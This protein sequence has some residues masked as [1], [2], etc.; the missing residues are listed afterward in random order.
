MLTLPEQTDRS[1]ELPATGG[2]GVTAII[3]ESGNKAVIADDGTVTRPDEDTA[4]TM[5][6]TIE[7]NGRKLTKDI[8]VT[9]LKKIWRNIPMN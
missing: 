1:L 2:S 3:W 5:T 7:A 4:V 8:V 9:V 6:A